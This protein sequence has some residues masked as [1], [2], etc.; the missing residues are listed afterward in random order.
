M[1]RARAHLPSLRGRLWLPAAPHALI[2][3]SFTRG[4]TDKGYSRFDG[5]RPDGPKATQR[6]FQA[7][8]KRFRYL[9]TRF[10]L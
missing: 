6:G 10:Q 8:W 9:A 3:L 1:R 2:R 5:P 7:V 4:P